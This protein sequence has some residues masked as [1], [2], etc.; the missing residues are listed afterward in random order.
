[1]NAPPEVPS[2]LRLAFQVW[3][4]ALVAYLVAQIL[5]LVFPP[6]A[7]DRAAYAAYVAGLHLPPDR[8]A[9]AMR[10]MGSVSGGTALFGVIVTALVVVPAVWVGLRM[11]AG[12]GGAR[13]MTL[14]VAVVGVLGGLGG[15]V[16]ALVSRLP[17][18]AG[19][20]AA[21]LQVI[22]GLLFVGYLVLLF[23]P[24]SA[25]YFTAA[26]AARP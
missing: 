9:Q 21:V 23:R 18:P 25:R 6:S 22:S 10:S 3:V 20:A 13:T 5:T 7:A 12:V 15:G 24:A 11:R 16:V 2:T 8:Q 26:A 1:V 4:A 14:V 17:V 19:G